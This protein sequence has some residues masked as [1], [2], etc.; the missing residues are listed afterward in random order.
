MEK[1]HVLGTGYALATR[2]YNT[3]FAITNERGTLLVDAGGGN[4]IL[5][6]MED[7]GIGFETVH[8]FFITHAHPDHE[9]IYALQMRGV[10]SCSVLPPEQEKYVASMSA[11]L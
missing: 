4:G 11:P 1:L 3:C 5:R 9:D 6:Q 7:A 2:V 8:D 10:A